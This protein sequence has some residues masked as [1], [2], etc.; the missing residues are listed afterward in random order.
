MER[1]GQINGK[2]RASEQYMGG[3][4]YGNNL[5]SAGG[6]NRNGSESQFK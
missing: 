2:T 3:Y 5:G 4:D 1:L 6:M